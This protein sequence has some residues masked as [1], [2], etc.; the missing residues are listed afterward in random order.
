MNEPFPA[1]W[2][3]PDA[4]DPWAN[5]PSRYLTSQG[6]AVRLLRLIAEHRRTSAS[7]EALL[8]VI[9]ARCRQ[10]LGQAA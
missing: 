3:D 2:L 7:A 6:F 10:L 1:A 4:P 9:E 5:V 8:E